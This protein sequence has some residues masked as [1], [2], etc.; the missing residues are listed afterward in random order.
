MP[1]KDYY[2][3]LGV[4]KNASL[5]EIKKA[6]RKLA[7]KYHPDKNPDNQKNAEERFK[8]ISEAY[9]VLENDKRRA[10]YD[11]YRGGYGGESG[12]QFTGTQG[13]NFDEILR[14]Y[15]GSARTSRAG[16]SGNNFED[17]FDVFKHMGR[18]GRTEYIYNSDFGNEKAR[19]LDVDTDINAS[20]ILPK[21]VAE[22]GGE[23]LF[24]HSGKKITLKIKAGTHTGQKLKIR[25]Q[26][27]MCSHCGHPGDLI[28]TIRVSR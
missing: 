13:F 26:G 17:I 21:N 18:G 8:K 22:K 19:P 10:E 11:A 9:Y 14:Q 23:A 7:L 5:E 20:L 28:V 15:A 16:F 6:Y 12:G 1:D 24:K 4:A 2:N 3:I 27:K 25:G